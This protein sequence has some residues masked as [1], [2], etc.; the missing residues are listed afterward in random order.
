MCA[1]RWRRC[2]ARLLKVYIDRG[3]ACELAVADGL[4]FSGDREDLTEIAGNLLDNAF[5]WARSRVSV[6]AN[7]SCASTP[8]ATA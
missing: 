1:R 7:A 6:T 5:K 8:A 3:L 2:A 4:Q